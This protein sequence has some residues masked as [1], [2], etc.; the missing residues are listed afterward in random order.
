MEQQEKDLPFLRPRSSPGWLSGDHTPQRREGP[1]G[2]S[3]P[4]TPA[5][6]GFRPLLRRLRGEHPLCRAGRSGLQTRLSGAILSQASAGK[7]R[8]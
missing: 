2:S 3:S 7:A 5:L 6:G 8:G 4:L 1:P